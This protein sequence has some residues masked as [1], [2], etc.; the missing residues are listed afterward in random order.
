MFAAVVQQVSS[1]VLSFTICLLPGP[2]DEN[3]KQSRVDCSCSEALGEKA[4]CCVR[5]FAHGA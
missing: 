3:R 2:R 1:A 4:V 5:A